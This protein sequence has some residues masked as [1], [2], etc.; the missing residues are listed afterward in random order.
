MQ[1][2]S[3]RPEQRSVGGGLGPAASVLSLALS[4]GWPLV[5]R[6][7]RSRSGDRS[8][9]YVS[10]QH[11]APDRLGRCV[12]GGSSHPRHGGLRPELCGLSCACGARQGAS[13]GDAF[14]KSF[15]QKTV[16]D[17]LEFVS[18]YMPNGTPGSLSEPTYRDIVA[19]MLKSNGFPAGTT[20][21]RAIPSASVQIVPKDGSTE[22]PADALVRVVGCL[23]KSGA[24]WV[25]TNATTPERAEPP[26]RARRSDETPRQPEDGAQ[27]RRDQVGCFGRFP[28]RGERAP[29]RRRRRGRHQRDDGEPRRP[30]VP[31]KVWS[32][33]SHPSR[34]PASGPSKSQRFPSRSRNTATLP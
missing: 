11:A 16:G 31:L 27:V 5:P 3:D 15:A 29:D 7:G 2:M 12:H 14:W 30:E 34:A 22:L 32:A 17:L 24:D 6:G 9:Q 8:D 33:C 18:T 4:A 13:G 23:T 10:G 21:S 1:A 26:L 19:L 28:R 20:S 25:V